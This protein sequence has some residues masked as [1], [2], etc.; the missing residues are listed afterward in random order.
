MRERAMIGVNAVISSGVIISEWHLISP[1]FLP[2]RKFVLPA[3]PAKM[4][5]GLLDAQCSTRLD[6]DREGESSAVASDR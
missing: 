4:S 2:W 1:D 3:M 5:A 6:C